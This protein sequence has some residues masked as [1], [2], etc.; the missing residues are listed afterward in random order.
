S[1][2]FASLGFEPVYWYK[3]QMQ[4]TVFLVFTLASIALLWTI[5][6]LVI[7]EEGYSR[8]PFLEIA[9]ERVT[10]PTTAVLK[11]LSAPIAVILGVVIGITFSTDWNTF[12]TFWNAVPSTGSTDPIF[13]RPVTF[14]LFTLPVLESVGSWLLF[15]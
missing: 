14:Y 12:A 4:G 7:P 3:L 9:G 1:L 11:R 5:F 8:R 10:I 6:R 2:W 15:I 13:A